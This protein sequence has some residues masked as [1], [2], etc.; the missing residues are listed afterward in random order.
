MKGAAV[1]MSLHFCVGGAILTLVVCLF[2]LF[3][4]LGSFLYG[5]LSREQLLVNLAVILTNLP[6]LYFMYRLCRYPDFLRTTARGYPFWFCVLG[7]GCSLAPLLLLGTKVVL[8]VWPWQ[9]SCLMSIYLE[10]TR[11]SFLLPHG[12]GDKK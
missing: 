2:A 8:I 12:R 7:L 11:F 10:E 9:L 4:V 6:Q 5:D 1:L 3:N